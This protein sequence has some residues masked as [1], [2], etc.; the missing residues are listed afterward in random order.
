MVCSACSV[1]LA[2]NPAKIT[3]SM[4]RWSMTCSRCLRAFSMAS[5][6]SGLSNRAQ[7]SFRRCC[8]AS[9]SSFGDRE[10]SSRNSPFSRAIFKAVSTTASLSTAIS[11]ALPSSPKGMPP[12]AFSMVAFAF[13]SSCLS[14]LTSR[15]PSAST[16]SS[17]RLPMTRFCMSPFRATCGARSR[18]LISV[19]S[20]F[21]T[22]TA[23][24]STKRSLAPLALLLTRFNPSA[25]RLRTP[26]PFICS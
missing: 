20:S 16:M 9:S 10:S 6:K 19:L 5:R 22:P 23:S 12:L 14:I 13:L 11:S 3:W 7:M 15:L 4:F 8:R 24:I 2:E 18:L 25:S 1:A 26:R 21:S 17:S